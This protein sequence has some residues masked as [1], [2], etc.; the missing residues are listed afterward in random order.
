MRGANVTV[1]RR[2][3]H[4]N[5]GIP[6]T[7][8]SYRTRLDQPAAFSRDGIVPVPRSVPGPLPSSPEGTP[9]L[10]ESV[11]TFITQDAANFAA[12]IPTP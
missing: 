4:L 7:G 2:G 1:G 11:D 12:R 10:E 3:T 8:L 6:G 5:L 9:E